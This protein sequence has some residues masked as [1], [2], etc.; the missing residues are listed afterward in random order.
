MKFA[1]DSSE[2]VVSPYYFE[3]LSCEAVSVA[4]ENG[5]FSIAVAAVVATLTM[6]IHTTWATSIFVTQTLYILYF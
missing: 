5:I 6:N 4:L 3:Q 1:T 2:A